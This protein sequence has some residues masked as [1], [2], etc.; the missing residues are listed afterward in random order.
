MKIFVWRHNKTHHSHSM[1]NEPCLNNNFYLDA[2]AV[3]AANS[4]NEAVQV[5]CD[6]KQGWRAEDLLEH[7]HE[8]YTL[9]EPKLLFSNI[10]GNIDFL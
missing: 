7:P 2:I 5:L 4:L 8:E 3:V 6:A 9:D 10:M 1:I